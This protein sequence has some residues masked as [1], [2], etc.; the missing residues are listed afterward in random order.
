MLNQHGFIKQLTDS[1]AGKINQSKLKQFNK[2]VAPSPYSIK[3]VHGGTERY[4]IDQHLF[5]VNEGNYLIVNAQDEFTIDFDNDEFAHGICIYPPEELIKQAFE[6]KN[7]S[8]KQLL[9]SDGNPN[10][11]PNFIHKV[12]S[13]KKTKTGIFLDQNLP[14]LTQKL[15]L[16]ESVDLNSFFLDLVDYMVIDQI[17]VNQHLKGHSATKKHTKEELFRRISLAK[18]YL[19][20]NFREKIN[21]DDLANMACLSKYHFLRSFKEFYG[22]TP[23][24]F[25]LN[26]KLHEAKQLQ[27]KGYSINE[28]SLIT[29]F[30]DPKNLR[31]ALKKIA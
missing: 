10:E 23:Y 3:Y 8:L 16:G 2:D 27:T 5:S 12:N 15:A 29:G 24:Q 21:I 22:Q 26:H 6:A 11:R 19:A 20:D 14:G 13:T 1:D 28:I 7:A 31:K 4:R 30:S 18:D 9:D 25:L 17:N